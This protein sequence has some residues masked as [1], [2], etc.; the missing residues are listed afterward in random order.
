METKNESALFTPDMIR[1]LQTVFS[2]MEQP[3]VLKCFL[4]ADPVSEQLQEYVTECC[5]LTDKL[6]WVSSREDCA[7]K[8]CVRICDQDGKD[9]GLAFHGVPG[10]H[11]FTSF[12]L[13]L[14]NVAGPGQTVGDRIRGKIEAIDK[15][16]RIT[17]LVSLSCTICPDVVQAAQRIGSMSPHVSVDVYDIQHFESLRTKY[18]VTRVPCL[19][20]NDREPVYGK[21]N[22][23]Q[24]LDMIKQG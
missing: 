12:I 4:D 14:Y 15:D 9:S 10:G 17:L 7:H 6:S 5:A 24:L 23:G 11:E 2:R 18:N 13:A 1:Q 8:P 16:I 3:L 19:I 21:K 22:I 20:L